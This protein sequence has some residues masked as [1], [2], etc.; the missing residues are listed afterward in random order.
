MNFFAVALRF[1]SYLFAFAVGLF[2]FAVGF[3]LLISGSSNFRLDMLPWF[4]EGA[5]IWALLLLGLL[6][7]I[8]SILALK[9][10]AKPLLA[11]FCTLALVLMAYGY[12]LSPI[13]RFDGSSE[14]WSTFA[15]T[16]GAL[17]A[18]FGA[19]MALRKSRA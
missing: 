10:R 4:K 13:Y 8:S 15:A 11:V 12:F 17:G 18:T 2:A 14:A 5:A 7:I 1:W 6:G 9:G 19:L 16:L 3:V